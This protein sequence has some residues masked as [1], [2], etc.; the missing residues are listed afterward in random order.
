VAVDTEALGN[1]TPPGPRGAPLVGSALDLKRDVLGTFH[2][3]MLEYG[4]V[5]R[6]VAGPPGPLRAQV[7]AFFHPDGVQHVLAGASG[8]YVKGDP[9]YQEIKSTLGDG[10][11]TSEGERW[12]RQ[13]RLIQPLFTHKRVASYVPMMAEEATTTVARWR[14]A[15]SR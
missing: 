10:L 6:F 8:T 1:A 11:L 2:R 9:V 12:R 13:K 4:D 15:A 14:D 5:V 7:I 3:A